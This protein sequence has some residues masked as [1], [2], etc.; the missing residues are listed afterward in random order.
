M[1][2]LCLL[3]PALLLVAAVVQAARTDTYVHPEMLV[4]PADLAKSELARQLVIL[5]ARSEKEYAQGHVP[6]ARRVDH[7]AWSKAFGDGQDAQ[8]WS[9]R[10]GALGIGPGT[11]VVVYDGKGLKEAARVWWILRYWG[12]NDVKLLNGDWKTWTAE[13]LPVD[14]QPPAT[15]AK[16]SFAAQA[17][18][19]RLANKDQMLDWV[20]GSGMQIVDTRSDKEFCGIDFQGNKRAGAMPGAKHLEWTELI[21]PKTHRF[22]SPAELRRLFD[23]A[24]IDL[25]RPTVTHCQS[26]GRASVTVFGMELMGA[27]DVRNYYKSWSE[28]GN[29]TDTPIVMAEQAAKKGATKASPAL[30]FTMKSLDGKE[31]DLRK[32]QGKVVLIVNVASKCGLTPQYK[33]LEALYEKY[34]KDGLVVVGFP[35]NQ[36]RQQEPGTPEE[37]QQFCTVNYRVTFPLFAKIEVNGE[38]VTALYKHLTALATKPTGAGPISWNFEKFILGRNGEVVARFGPRTKPDAPEV[39]AVIEAELSRK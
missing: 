28:W 29:A 36:F 26:G 7:D 32:Y 27:R 16:A 10:I 20:K 33:Q 39:L 4:E 35:C 2:T 12:L 18:A 37:I 30:S 3:L 1:K 5:D 15:A 38:G 25:A 14:K 34:G 21:D 13:S 8:G 19:Q 11:K 24:G 23:K 22:K 31:V 6:G 17:R 9:K